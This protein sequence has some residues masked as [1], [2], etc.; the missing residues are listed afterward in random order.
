MLVPISGR[1]LSLNDALFD[2]SD[3]IIK[4]PY[5]EGWLY[6]VVPVDLNYELANLTS[7]SSDRF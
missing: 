3:L 1:I 4:D 2:E 5:F 7:C 6:R